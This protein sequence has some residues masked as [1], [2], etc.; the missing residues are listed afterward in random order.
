MFAIAIIVLTAVPFALVLA[1]VT[2]ATVRGLFQK[3]PLV[4][5]LTMSLV[6]TVAVVLSA[7]GVAAIKRRRNPSR[8]NT[9]T[10]ASQCVNPARDRRDGLDVN[11]VRRLAAEINDILKASPLSAHRKADL[12]VQLRAVP[13]TLAHAMSRLN[14]LHRIKDIADRAPDAEYAERVQR[15][16][17]A[18]EAEVQ[19]QVHTLHKTLLDMSVVLLRVDK[20][21]DDRALERLMTELSAANERLDNVAASYT[22]VQAERR[23]YNLQL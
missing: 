13:S 16:L 11:D 22:D 4:A 20:A 17:A 15:D 21:K 6:G 18:M 1:A 9:S 7:A 14:R 5:A 10:N 19:T 12:A 8:S 3:G 23:A 2:Y